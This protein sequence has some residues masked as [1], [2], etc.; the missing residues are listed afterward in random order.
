MK[1]QIF[2]EVKQV[3]LHEV[4]LASN[5]ALDHVDESESHLGS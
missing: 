5:S 4:G 1:K 2:R 3:N